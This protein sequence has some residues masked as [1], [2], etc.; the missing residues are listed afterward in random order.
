[1]RQL[2]IIFLFPM[3]FYFSRSF[4]QVSAIDFYPLQIG[5]KWEFKIES[6]LSP[7]LMD[8]YDK[9]SI[10]VLGDSILPNG[11]K[12]SILQK[13]YTPEVT[14]PELYF[15]RIDSSTFNIYRYNNGYYFPIPFI[16][17]FLIDSLEASV[18]DIIS[19]NYMCRITNTVV[20]CNYLEFSQDSILGQWANIKKFVSGGLLEVDNHYWLVDGIGLA[21]IATVDLNGYDTLYTWHLTYAKIGAKEYGLKTDIKNSNK[22]NL[23]SFRLY[24]NHPNPFNPSTTIEFTLSKDE[25]ITLKIYNLNGELVAVLLEKQLS[26]GMHRVD[27]NASGLASGVYLYRLVAENFVQSKKLIL[28]R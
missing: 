14:S 4:A 6:K 26:A 25:N 8:M 12:Y 22:L 27:W 16:D 11:K 18:G 20:R 13:K 10:E 7:P 1:M 17:E 3:L 24:Q 23:N 9:L 28:M 5:N 15:D 19:R 21:Y 2:R